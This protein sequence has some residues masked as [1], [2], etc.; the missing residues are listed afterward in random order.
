LTSNVLG[1]NLTFYGLLPVFNQT[2][3]ISDK[4]NYNF[5]LSSTFD[6]FKQTTNGISYPA[7]DLQ[8]YIQPSVIYVYSPNLN[9]SGSYTYQRN[10]PINENS[11]NEHRLW[12]QTI[13]S[14]NL[15]KGKITNRFRFEERF[16]QNKSLNTYPLSTRL[17]YQ[18]G[19]NRPLQ[20]KTLD[21]NEFYLN[22][23]NEFYFSLTGNKNATYSENWSYLGVGYDIG[24]LG[25]LELGYMF[26]VLVRNKVSDLRLLNLAQIAWITN[27][28]FKK[29]SN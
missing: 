23:Y 16:I 17:R 25:R 3:R 14:F 20:G 6:A 1:Q 5:F 7:T 24:K 28:N 11:T 29:K 15:D 8:L 19:L 4:F 10:N 12:Q 22:A 13:F 21:Q 27:F 2:G 18:I 26:Q 9:F